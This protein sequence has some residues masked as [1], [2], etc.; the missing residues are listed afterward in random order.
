MDME[1]LSMRKITEIL[2]LK[3]ELDLSERQI[4]K[5]TQVACQSAPDS[6]QFSAFGNSQRSAYNL[7]QHQHDWQRLMLIAGKNSALI[8]SHDSAGSQ[9]RVNMSVFTGKCYPPLV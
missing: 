9:H 6:F 2:R 7:A 1:K 8:D 5:S 3:F 4:S